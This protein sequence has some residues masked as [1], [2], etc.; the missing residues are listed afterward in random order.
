MKSRWTGLLLCL[1]LLLPALTVIP[2]SGRDD[3][4]VDVT[5]SDSKFHVEIDIDISLEIDDLTQF[6]DA[7]DAYS[8]NA[9]AF[10][11]DLRESIEDAVQ[12]LLPEATVTGLEIE[13][14]NCDEAT[15]DMLIL[16]SFDVEGAITEGETVEYNLIWRTFVA[17]QKVHAADRQIQPEEALGLDFHDF[18]DD[19]DEWEVAESS[20]NTVIWE[21]KEYE[22]EAD[23][24]DVELRVE[25]TFTLPGT[26][27]TI[28]EDK[29][30]AKET[31]KQTQDTQPP[32]QI[33]GFPWEATV[34][35]VILATI[36]TIIQRKRGQKC[37]V[38]QIKSD[39][40]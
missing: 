38:Y 2:V 1:T 26:G 18:K 21:E 6:I 19:L 22:L 37:P 10:R 4:T 8:R 20:G 31:A 7:E 15:K 17:T 11:G 27:M 24:G 25:M 39:R 33:P 14:I 13:E 30:T 29:V 16:L 5:V 28:G 23:D 40:R 3:S 12:E 9:G 36:I 35:G 32:P 34:I